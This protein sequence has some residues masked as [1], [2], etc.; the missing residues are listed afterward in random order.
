MCR[1][2][3]DVHVREGKPEPG[4]NDRDDGT[5]WIAKTLA[6]LNA[7]PTSA[8]PS[9]KEGKSDK[10]DVEQREGGRKTCM[11]DSGCRR[12]P[13]ARR[14]NARSILP[15]SGRGNLVTRGSLSSKMANEGFIQ[16]RLM[17]G[18]DA[19]W[20]ARQARN[21]PLSR[22]YC[23]EL[24]GLSERSPVVCHHLRHEGQRWKS[25]PYRLARWTQ[26]R[27]SLMQDTL[28]I[29]SIDANQS[30][31]G[32]C[33]CSLVLSRPPGLERSMGA[34]VLLAFHMA[35]IAMLRCAV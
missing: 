1:S 21:R 30:C 22:W 2:Q 3:A 28:A 24:A 16:R 4:F 5:C 31:H 11:R 7:T 20:P 34:V 9:E 13:N 15:L 14:C 8:S 32:S 26:S 10:V 25:G 33:L 27:I 23:H 17:D 19:E 29:D 18:R 12:R 35:F 6:K